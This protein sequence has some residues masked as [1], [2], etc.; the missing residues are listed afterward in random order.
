MRKTACL[1]LG[2]C[3]YIF[4][5]LFLTQNADAAKPSEA[6]QSWINC[7][8]WDTIFD[9]AGYT[10]EM[11]WGN[12]PYHPHTY[13]ELMSGEWAAAIYYDGIATGSKAMWLT[14]KFR[15]PTWYPNPNDF[16][17]DTGAFLKDDPNNPVNGD[18]TGRSVIKNSQVKVTIDYEVVDLA[19]FGWWSPLT[20]REPNDANVSISRSERY[21]FLQT[22]TIKNIKT[23]GNITGLEFYQ[24]LHSHGDDD[25]GPVVH[26]SYNDT[27][28]NDPLKNY[29]PYNPVHTVGNFRY[30]I[31]Q[32]NNPDDPLASADH[33]DWVG[34]FPSKIKNYFLVLQFN[35]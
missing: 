29:V 27:D 30:D 11:N 25:Y 35:K 19:G 10:D 18:D 13:H 15:V 14:D 34:N 12:S 21:I 8:Y 20:Y 16:V 7:D 26:C 23:S 32:W 33:T 2:I 6:Y 9:A 22:Y 1:K 24:M 5:V 4:A 31:T 17:I 3:L 28:V